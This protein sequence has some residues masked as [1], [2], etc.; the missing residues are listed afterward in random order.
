MVGFYSGVAWRNQSRLPYRDDLIPYSDASK[1]GDV[2]MYLD[3]RLGRRM[4]DTTSYQ[5]TFAQAKLT[6]AYFISDNSRVEA[7]AGIRGRW[8]EDYHSE[9]RTDYRP[10]VGV[11]LY[12]SPDWLT[13]LVKRSEISLNFDFYRNFS[14]ISEKNYTLW[15]VGPTLSL[16]T[17]F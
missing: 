2:S 17:K 9:K 15:E 4:S 11:A 1:G 7:T 6:G 8:Y 10:S 5:N 14:N 13:K 16:R 12:W 3:V